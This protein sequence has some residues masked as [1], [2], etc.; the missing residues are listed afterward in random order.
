[1]ENQ[2]R[3]LN[4]LPYYP[5]IKGVDKYNS[6]YIRAFAQLLTDDE[7][8]EVSKYTEINNIIRE[9]IINLNDNGT[10]NYHFETVPIKRMITN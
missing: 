4:D 3:K 8:E 2:K 1:M 7:P 10:D 9:L 5:Y 6:V